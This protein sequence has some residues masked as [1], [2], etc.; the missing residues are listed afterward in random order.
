MKREIFWIKKGH[1]MTNVQYYDNAITHVAV[2]Q[3]Y[4]GGIDLDMKMIEAELHDTYG[5]S[6]LFEADSTQP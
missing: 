2:L 5:V 6:T 4:G 1:Q 3:S